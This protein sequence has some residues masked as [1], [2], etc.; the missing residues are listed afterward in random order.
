MNDTNEFNLYD[1]RYLRLKSVLELIPV[2]RSTW[3]LWI[4]HGIVP[5]PTHTFLRVF[6]HGKY[7]KLKIYWTIWA[8]LTGL[9]MLRKK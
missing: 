5:R 6:L 3:Y 9:V 7:K 2:S 4:H 8:S 1:H